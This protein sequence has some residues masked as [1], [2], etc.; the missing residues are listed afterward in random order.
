MS[1]LALEPHLGL[2]LVHSQEVPRSGEIILLQMRKW[3]MKFCE[4]L[5]KERTD[6]NLSLSVP[7]ATTLC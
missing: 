5:P 2:A 7:K 1:C 4:S 6:L 3:R